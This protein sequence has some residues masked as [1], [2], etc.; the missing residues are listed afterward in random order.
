MWSKSIAAPRAATDL[1][2]FK[3]RAPF[4]MR[5]TADANTVPIFKQQT[6]VGLGLR[7]AAR[8]GCLGAGKVLSK[9]NV[10]LS[11]TRGL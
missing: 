9:L 8:V 10:I 2:E 7:G 3:G 5:N 4:Q 6:S 1:G 11:A